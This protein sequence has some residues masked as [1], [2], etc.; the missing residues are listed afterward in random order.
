VVGY[1][2]PVELHAPEGTAIS[3]AEDGRFGQPQA[4][5]VKAGL[6]IGQ[7]YRFRVMNIPLNPGVE[8]FPTVEVVDRLYSP[9][10]Q[11]Q[12]FPIV[13]ELTQE[14]LLLAASGKFVTRV[15][16]LE[17]P[18]RAL[19]VATDP[20]HQAWFDVPP[21][22]DPL[23]VADEMGRPMAILRLGAIVPNSSEGWDAAFLFGCPPLVRYPPSEKPAPA[24]AVSQRSER[25]ATPVASRRTG[26]AWTRQSAAAWES[27]VR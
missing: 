13:V 26:A 19:P 16:Y 6:L 3:L 5:P 9:R 8:V 17:D 15:I 25:G 27:P 20:A 10:G 18:R 22:R 21:G 12:R 7:V 1:F 2:Q 4:A 23:A 11:E 14:D 24:E